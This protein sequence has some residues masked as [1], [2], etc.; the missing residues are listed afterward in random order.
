MVDGEH[1]AGS[2]SPAEEVDDACEECP[3]GGG[4]ADESGDDEDGAEESADGMVCHFAAGYFEYGEECEDVRDHHDEVCDGESENGNEVLPEGS[5]SGAVSSDLRNGV[6][7]EDENADD[8]DEYASDDA[9][10]SIVLFDLVLEHGVEEQGDHGHECI[11]TGD[12]DTG[13]DP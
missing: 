2:E 4:A 5:F 8:N 13:N 10:E 6:L 7:S 3:P 9:Q 1:V 11:G 12:A